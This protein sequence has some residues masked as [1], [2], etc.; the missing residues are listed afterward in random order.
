MSNS[1]QA[2]AKKSVI[3]V[4]V[5]EDND[6]DFLLIQRKLLKLLTPTIIDRAT[7]RNELHVALLAARD[8]IVTDYHLAD[9]EE[10]ELI[11][12]IHAAQPATPCLILSGSIDHID[13]RDLQENVIAVIEKGD[14]AA[15]E[16]A[17]RDYFDEPAAP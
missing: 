17:L 10:R 3:N 2:R 12:A 14:S 1:Q 4:L 7:N 15:L 11:T 9:I 13:A 16:K 5:V 6:T 8:L